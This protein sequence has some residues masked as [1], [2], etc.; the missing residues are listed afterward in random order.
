MDEDSGYTCPRFVAHLHFPLFFH[1]RTIRKNG[2]FMKILIFR[3]C[4]YTSAHSSNFTCKSTRLLWKKVTTSGSCV[5]CIS[6]LP[7]SAI[8]LWIVVYDRHGLPLVARVNAD[9]LPVI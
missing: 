1:K 2:K 6:S 9:L 8:Q 7:W 4:V 5:Q 3:A